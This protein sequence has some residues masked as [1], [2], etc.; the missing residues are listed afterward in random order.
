MKDEIREAEED[1]LLD[2]HVCREDFDKSDQIL[3]KSLNTI[4]KC[5]LLATNHIP[6]RATILDLRFDGCPHSTWKADMS[7]DPGLDCRANMSVPTT[8]SIHESFFAQMR[9]ILNFYAQ[10]DY[11]LPPRV[12]HIHDGHRSAMKSPRSP[13]FSGL[14]RRARRL[15]IDNITSGTRPRRGSNAGA[16]AAAYS[17]MPPELWL[18][19]F[20]HIPLYLLPSVTLTCRS[21]RS[22]AQPLLFT[23]I[24]THPEDSR[25][26]QTAKYRKRVADRV[27]FFFSPQISLTVRS[28]K[29]S[30]PSPEEDGFPDDILIDYIF[31]TLSK[32]PNL[33]VLDCRHIRLTPKRLAILQSLHLQTISLEMCFGEISDFPVSVP[34]QEVTFKYPDSL[35]RNKE[36]PCEIF[37]AP[38]RLEHLHATTTM[39]L[40]PIAL[41]IPFTKL[42]TLHLPV[43]CLPSDCFIP[44]L[45]R[46][47]AV[48]H[49]TLHTTD[50]LPN[51]PFDVLPDGVLPLLTSYKGP[52]H[53]AACFLSGRTA[54]RVD[55]SVPCRPHSLQSSLVKLERNLLSLSFCLSTADFPTALLA[56]IHAAFP[57]LSSLSVVGSQL[58]SSE[59]K[60]LLGAV[61]PHHVL[62]ELTLR[63]QG[64][65]KYNLWIPPE[66]AAADA[67]SCFGKVRS[68][69]LRTYPAIRRVK[70]V[71]SVEGGS[72]VWHRS[73][74]SGLFL[75]VAE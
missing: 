73:P 27:E 35:S 71:H 67:V 59:I 9:V 41:S 37:L 47:P 43:E 25:G 39:V 46:C 65:D 54:R 34:L 6:I 68:A 20:A 49:L 42:R 60:A 33:R 4:T 11:L 74:S 2:D 57:V 30:P 10:I 23:T 16:A 52:H 19:V 8:W 40:S 31:D 22:L 12:P 56:T 14:V 32:L 61:G 21:F 24:S 1:L 5:A 58:S 55:I 75:Q 51:R 63:I 72:V 50:F 44:A 3:G 38:S 18:K 15:T 70:F 36:S 64:R 69:L 66:E 62:A 17:V 29:I 7:E 48:E 13:M 53:F 26:T 45:W 28:C